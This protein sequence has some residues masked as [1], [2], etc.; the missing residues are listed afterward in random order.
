M[1]KRNGGTVGGAVSD[2]TGAEK[3]AKAREEGVL[4][5]M[6]GKTPEAGTALL[7]GQRKKSPRERD[8]GLGCCSCCDGVG[9]IADMTT[10][11]GIDYYCAECTEPGHVGPCLELAYEQE[12]EE[13][14]RNG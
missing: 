3:R 8:K 5:L 13:R 4:A 1:A 11:N 7:T 14:K 9:E 6:T 12:R 10:A 2:A